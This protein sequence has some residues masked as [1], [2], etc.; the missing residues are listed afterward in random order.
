VWCR[1]WHE[2]LAG[3][4]ARC[5]RSPARLG[6]VTDKLTPER[7]SENMRR[8][9]SRDTSPEM[10]VRRAVHGMGFRY[11]L[12]VANLPGKPDLVFPRH[13]KIVEVR[14]CFWHQHG[15]CVDSHIPKSRR[16]YWIPK[17]EGNRSRDAAN[18]RS[19]KALGF[20]VLVVWECEAA[21]KSRLTAKLRRFLG[22]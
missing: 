6:F 12:H 3:D 10:L 8:I 16:S 19:L 5:F 2:L 22:G 18:L 14:G 15:K 13:S 1:P 21:N 9:R 20:R 11:R 4:R 7:R 17:L